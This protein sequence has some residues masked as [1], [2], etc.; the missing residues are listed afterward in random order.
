MTPS[1]SAIASTLSVLESSISST[2]SS[3][4]DRCWPSLPVRFEGACMKSED[5][6]GQEDI[7]GGSDGLDAAAR[8]TVFWKEKR[9]VALCKS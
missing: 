3:M 9:S 8:D 2:L 1:S 5:S 7:M 6:V 4:V